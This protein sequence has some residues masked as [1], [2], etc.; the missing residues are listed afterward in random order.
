MVAEDLQMFLTEDQIMKILKD[1]AMFS[2]SIS[3]R[4]RAVRQLANN[5]GFRAV[6]FIT[7][8]IETIP[9]NDNGFRAFCVQSIAKIK[10]ELANQFF[11]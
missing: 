3:T 10:H 5:Y 8:V 7:E 2:D 4:T 6:P 9:H 1:E 11:D